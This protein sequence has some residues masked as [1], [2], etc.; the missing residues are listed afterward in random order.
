MQ[1]VLVAG[2][3]GSGKTTVARR[4]ADVLGL[5]HTEIDALFHGPG[6]TPRPTFSDEVEQLAARPGWVTEWQYD[7]VRPLLAA[8]ADTLVWLH[9]PRCTVMRR[10]LWRTVSRR[11][12]RDVLWNGNTEPPLRSF[13]TDP[14]HVVRWGWRTHDGNAAKVSQAVHDHP[15]LQVVELRS[16]RDVEAWLA[17]LSDGRETARDR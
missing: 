5:E 12:R 15:H 4:V 8:R 9:L 3:S 17:R 6:W 14:D 7:V 13:F 11:L 2:T 16:P 1:R 10:L